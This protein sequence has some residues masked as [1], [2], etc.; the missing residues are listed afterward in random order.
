M[1]F[2]PHAELNL[3]ETE[4]ELADQRHLF[5]RVLLYG[6]THLITHLKTFEKEKQVAG[7]RYL[8]TIDFETLDLVHAHARSFTRTW[9]SATS[10]GRGLRPVIR[11]CS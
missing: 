8:R 2:S 11:K 10:E 6:H 1:Y 7:V 9:F 4:S 3:Y 5:A